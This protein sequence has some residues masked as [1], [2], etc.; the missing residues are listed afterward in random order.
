M[1]P[2]ISF[3]ADQASSQ[4]SQT[5]DN[6]GMEPVYYN[7]A[8]KGEI[9]VFKNIEEERAPQENLENGVNSAVQKM[10][11]MTNNEKDVALHETVRGNHFKVVERLIKEGRDFSYSHN[12]A[13]ETQWR[14]QEFCLGCF[15]STLKKFRVISIY[16][17]C[18]RIFR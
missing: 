15:Y 7:A 12:D 2:S 10:L 4:P 17:E 8:E 11:E 5:E 13:G 1:D 3:E 14:L 16:F 9:G 18:F 6:I